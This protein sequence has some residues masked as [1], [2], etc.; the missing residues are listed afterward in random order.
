MSAN[1]L[2][3]TQ[4]PDAAAAQLQKGLDSGIYEGDPFEDARRHI[5]K[6]VAEKERAC[7]S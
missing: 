1:V 4:T 2:N 5:K 7:G 6:R 3:G